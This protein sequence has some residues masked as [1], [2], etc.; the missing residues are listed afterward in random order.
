MVIVRLSRVYKLLFVAVAKECTLLSLFALGW[1]ASQVFPLN[2]R[3]DRTTVTV[4]RDRKRYKLIHLLCFTKVFFNLQTPTG[5]VLNPHCSIV[6]G[7]T[8]EIGDKNITLNVSVALFM[9]IESCI[10]RTR[11]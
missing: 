3:N 7:Q 8:S 1:Q 4:E 6:I 11:I 5:Q 9:Y 2:N 10:N